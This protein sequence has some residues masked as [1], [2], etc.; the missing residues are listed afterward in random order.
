[1]KDLNFKDLAAKYKAL[2]AKTKN[3]IMVILGIAIFLGA[4][5]LGF[6]KL[7]ESTTA[8]QEEI[9]TQSAK[10]AELKG[11]YDSLDVYKKGIDE[12]KQAINKNLSKLPF[13]IK[14]EDYLM[15]VKTMNEDIG[16][17]LSNIS[18]EADNFIGEFGCQINDQNV[19]AS[20]MSSS[21]SFSSRM[22]YKQFKE[23]LQYI[24]DDTRKVTFI[25]TV[26]ITF[27]STE[28]ILD[29]TFGITK[30]YIEYEGCDYVPVPV[31]NVATGTSDPFGLE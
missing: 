19:T 14:S 21:V 18:F 13:G 10:V 12:D 23:M 22:N 9:G 3:L 28:V 4:Y 11:Y 8:L 27:D 6:T 20:A 25:D 7:Q 24:Y 17:K 2:P 1:M 31:P 26:S 16:A 29:T 5:M 30:Y 15:Y